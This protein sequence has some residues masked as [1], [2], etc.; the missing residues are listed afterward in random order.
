MK[1][2]PK[3]GTEKP[4]AEFGRNAR[5]PDGV[6]SECR[7]CRSEYDKQRYQTHGADVRAQRATVE[8]RRKR[9]ASRHGLTVAQLERLIAKYDGMCWIC[10]VEPGTVVDHCHATKRR[11]GW[12]CHGCNAGLGHFRDDP[13]RLRAAA[14]YLRG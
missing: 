6:Q 8:G 3:C 1:R 10:R 11:R 2:C 7:S 13:K 14:V 4:L 9:Q 5:R 12:L